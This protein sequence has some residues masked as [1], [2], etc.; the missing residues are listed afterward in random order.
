MGI[1]KNIASNWFVLAFWG[2][3]I[4][5]G[6]FY[7]HDLLFYIA[8]IFGALMLAGFILS[9]LWWIVSLKYGKEFLVCFVFLYLAVSAII[10]L[11]KQP[12]TP[13]FIEDQE[14]EEQYERSRRY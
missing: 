3:I 8:C 14:Q 2:V 7:S 13:S 9:I 4:L 11:F 12:H 5:L 1:L 10:I 6:V